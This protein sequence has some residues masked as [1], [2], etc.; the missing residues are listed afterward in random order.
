MPETHH[1]A[2]NAV[3][4]GMVPISS[5]DG[6]TLS[7]SRLNRLGRD[8]PPSGRS[9]LETLPN[10]VKD[11]I[12]GEALTGNPVHDAKTLKSI[13]QTSKTLRVFVSPSD[14]DPGN[15]SASSRVAKYNYHN[16]ELTEA[17]QLAR[18]LYQNVMVAPYYGNDLIKHAPDAVDRVKAMAP[19]LKFQPSDVKSRLVSDICALSSGVSYSRK[20]VKMLTAIGPH[21][22]AFNA[23]DRRTLISQAV[24]L[25]N[26]NNGNHETWDAITAMSGHPARYHMGPLLPELRQRRDNSIGRTNENSAS[27]V[28]DQN[29]V[30][31]QDQNNVDV[32]ELRRT[33]DTIRNTP[34]GAP[35]E[36]YWDVA[37]GIATR[38]ELSGQELTKFTKEMPDRP[39]RRR[40]LMNSERERSGRGL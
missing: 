25:A 35:M 39:D 24:D 31:R 11:Q 7:T 28:G 34:G 17:G 12:F 26:N 9:R 38:C 40:E 19:I 23:D 20:K 22:D 1:E 16:K 2:E 13:G 18:E 3:F 32:A 37:R 21:L 33:F 30:S 29:I 10:E 8:G 36:R 5:V 4:E 15:P 6:D 27:A 14:F